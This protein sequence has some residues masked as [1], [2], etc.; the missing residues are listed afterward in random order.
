[1]I[2][3]EKGYKKVMDEKNTIYCKKNSDDLKNASRDNTNIFENFILR[4]IPIN[5]YIRVIWKFIL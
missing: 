3:D 2:D 4:N 1:M 5:M